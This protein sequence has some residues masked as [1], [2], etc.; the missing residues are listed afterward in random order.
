M[1][2]LIDFLQAEDWED[3]R[4][5]YLVGIA[6]GHATFQKGAPSWGEWDAGHSR[7]C[8]LAARSEGKV[9]GW[10]AL[11]PVSSRCVYEGV[12]EVSVYVKQD[13]KGKGIGGLLLKS[14]IS[15]SERNG[16]WTLQAGIFPEN[17][18]SLQLHKKCGFREVGRRE[19]IGKMDGVWRDTILLERRS[20]VVGI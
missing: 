2:I 16:Y 11:S 14:L 17:A 15:E 12:A 7:D 9:L 1:N 10:A 8:R 19:R 20:N 3:A 13:S 18:A 5:I 6:T 4:A